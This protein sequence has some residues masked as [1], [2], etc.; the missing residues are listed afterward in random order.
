MNELYQPCGRCGTEPVCLDCFNCEEHCT[1]PSPAE[2]R[3]E[4]ARRQASRKIRSG[5]NLIEK[6]IERLGVSCDSISV[7]G[8]II[9]DGRQYH[10]GAGYGPGAVVRQASDGTL[11]LTTHTGS[12][13]PEWSQYSVILVGE[14]NPDIV[15]ALQQLEE[16]GLPLTVQQ[17]EAFR[18]I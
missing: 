1:C 8:D 11:F 9:R 3:E 10:V 4:E 6:Y 18:G 7:A 13:V 17:A 14:E 2:Q 16:G 12:N 5:F 15:A